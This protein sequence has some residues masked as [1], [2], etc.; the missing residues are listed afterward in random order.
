MGTS[1]ACFAGTFPRGEG[2]WMHT[3]NFHHDRGVHHLPASLPYDLVPRL[4]HGGHD[5]VIGH[6][7]VDGGALVLQ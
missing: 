6:V 2:F 3:D 4:F 1:S 7:F 5:G